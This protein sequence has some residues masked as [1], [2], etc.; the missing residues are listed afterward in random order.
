MGRMGASKRV[1]IST[2]VT[3]EEAAFIDAVRGPDMTRPEFLRRIVRNNIRQTV[4]AVNSM[5]PGL[6]QALLDETT[7]RDAR[8]ARNR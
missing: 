1:T 6:R 7:A 3:E 2:T 8:L 5:S 4:A